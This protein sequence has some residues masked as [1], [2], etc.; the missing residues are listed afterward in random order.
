MATTTLAKSIPVPKKRAEGLAVMI[1]T[2]I[3]AR[4]P[5]GLACFYGVLIVLLIAALYP[6]IAKANL[7]SY[8]SS[9]LLSGILGAHIT[10]LSGFTTFLAVEVYSTI[11]G[12]LF[13]GF[14]AWIAG[15]ALPVTIENGTLDLALSRPISRTRYYLES[16]LGVL[17]SGAIVGL[18]TVFAVWIDTFIVKNS[19]IHLHWLR[20]TPLLHWLSFF[21]SA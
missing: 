7:G 17:I 15:A 16:Y 3:N 13:G 5:L 12:L 19:G 18:V 8:V 6:T 21:F 20:S 2:I 9:S 11:Y 4:T 10:N 1:R 14:L